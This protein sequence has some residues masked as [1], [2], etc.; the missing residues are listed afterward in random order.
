[1][2]FCEKDTNQ[3]NWYTAFI[4]RDNQWY[5]DM[6]LLWDF[7]TS[8]PPSVSV[9]VRRKTSSLYQLLVPKLRKESSQDRT[10]FSA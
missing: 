9:E 5:K 1:M 6:E 4:P 10:I 7:W 2:F 8:L 3:P